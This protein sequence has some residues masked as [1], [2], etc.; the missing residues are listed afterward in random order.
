MQDINDFKYLIKTKLSEKYPNIDGWFSSLTFAYD[1]QTAQLTIGFPHKFFA[2]WFFTQHK[3]EFEHCLKSNA[4]MIYGVT[5]TLVYTQNIQ[6][7]KNENNFFEKI[8]IEK[9]DDVFKN[10]IYNSKNEF[11]VMVAKEIIK[12]PFLNK[13]N[14]L[15]FYGKNCTGK[16]TLLQCIATA[17]VHK[18]FQAHH[19]FNADSDV[20]CDLLYEYDIKDICNKYSVFIIDD[21]HDDII[22]NLEKKFIQFVKFCVKN[23]ILVICATTQNS[24]FSMQWIEKLQSHIYS[25]MLVHVK[26]SDIDVRMRYILSKCEKYNIKLHKESILLLAQRCINIDIL[27]SVFLKIDAFVSLYNRQLKKQDVENILFSENEEIK[28]LSPDAIISFVAKYFTISEENILGNKKNP[29]IVHAR[30]MTMYLCRDLL[31]LSYPAIGK[32]FG[33]KDHSTVIYAIKKIKHLADTNN[34]CKLWGQLYALNSWP[35]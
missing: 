7:P 31:G 24:Q 19:V 5:P 25:V 13:Y 33:G 11:A 22:S 6:K 14:P 8:K 21:L 30:Y 35:C 26:N 16:T 10:F 20:F 15:I 32:I 27:K 3:E 12:N 23:N 1:I 28:N 9:K 18:H 2:S 4:L 34:I 29:D 17:I